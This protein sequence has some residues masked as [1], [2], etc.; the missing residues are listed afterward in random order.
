MHVGEQGDEHRFA[1][2]L[3]AREPLA[4]R[5]A[6]AR[7]TDRRDEGEWGGAGGGAHARDDAF[8]REPGEVIQAQLGDVRARRLRLPEVGDA[9]GGGNGGHEPGAVADPDPADSNRWHPVFS[10]RIP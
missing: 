10:P 3:V 9:L 7:G 8:L 1:A 4:A 2:L 5:A 6:L